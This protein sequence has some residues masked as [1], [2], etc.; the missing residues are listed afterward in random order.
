[1]P[2]S[3]PGRIGARL[4][5]GVLAVVIA[6]IGVSF[7]EGVSDVSNASSIY[8]V[9]VV[10]TAVAA[11]TAG[12]IVAAV[13]SI[14]IYDFFFTNP[15]HTLI[16]ADPGELLSLVVLLFVGVTVGQ[17]AALQRN[18]A[19]V[20][21]AREREAR[22]LFQVTRA[23][24]TRGSTDEV[25]P[26]IAAALVVDAGMDRVWF[27]L[28]P[29]D[30]RE[31]V[32][33]S[34]GGGAAPS[35]PAVYAILH[36]GPGSEPA[37][38]TL[39]R[40]PTARRAIGVADE[41]SYRVRIEAGGTVLGSI[42]ST[43]ARDDGEPDRTATRL[44]AAAA[45]QIGQA[46][47]Q[48][49][50]AADARLAEIATQSDALKS[51]LLESVSHDLRTP[52]ASIRASAGTLMDPDVVVSWDDVRSS[53]TSIDREADRL[54]TLVANLLDLGRIEGGALRAAREA[55]DLEDFVLRAVGLVEPRLAG[56]QVA[57]EVRGAPVVLGD[58]VLLEEILLN[59]LDNAIRHTPPETRIRIT[60][61]ERPENDLV[62]LTIEDSGRG[63]PEAALD[64]LFEKFYRLPPAGAGSRS[65][66]GIGL[67]VV[68]GLIEAMSGR[69]TARASELGGLAIEID[70]PL[71]R[72]PSGALL[73]PS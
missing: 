59:V 5:I 70:L 45:D 46:L 4:A 71:A 17:L 62:R 50:L 31:R 7:V 53:A 20:A 47:A 16:V 58:P 52:L 1:M 26:V 9:A 42:W 68:R 15:R 73:E 57:V 41:R 29:D 64:R 43:R 3:R 18:R 19:E 38:W 54:N 66:T 36:R 8:L 30:P 40:E 23:L 60:W 51:A 61:R 24:A 67:A 39:V 14:A 44:L 35:R 63:V 55:L 69:V 34:S 56:R 22:A 27:A 10:L 25:L 48:D 13:A 6:T 11:G 72:I 28:G 21:L 32:V 33:A 12:A 37:K 2:T 49:R 65:G